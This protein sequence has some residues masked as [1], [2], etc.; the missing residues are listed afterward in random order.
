[1]GLSFIRYPER[2]LLAGGFPTVLRNQRG[3]LFWFE[4]NR[5]FWLKG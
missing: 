2:L 5:T 4:S 3:S 1:M